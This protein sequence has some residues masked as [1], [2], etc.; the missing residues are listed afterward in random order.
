[1]Q[2]EQDYQYYGRRM[3][4]IASQAEAKFA[5]ERPLK[6]TSNMIGLIKEETPQRKKMPL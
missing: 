5:G 1:M 3:S 2:Q 6:S 4:N